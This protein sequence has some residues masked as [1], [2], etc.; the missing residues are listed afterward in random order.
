MSFSE[1]LGLRL[2]WILQNLKYVEGHVELLC[3]WDLSELEI[4]ICFLYTSRTQPEGH[5]MW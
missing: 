2:F 5:F 3:R 4:L 1:R